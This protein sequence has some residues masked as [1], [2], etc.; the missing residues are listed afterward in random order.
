MTMLTLLLFA[1][2]TKDLP[3]PP[4]GDATDDTGTVDTTGGSDGAETSEPVETAGPHDSATAV[5]TS[6]PVETGGALEPLVGDC[7]APADL[8]VDPLVVTGIYGTPAAKDIEFELIAIDQ[9]VDPDYVYASGQG[10]LQIFRVDDGVTKMGS[11]SGPRN[12][13]FD[14]TTIDAQHVAVAHW[15]YGVEI[16]SVTNPGTPMLLTQL[17]VPSA[18]RTAVHGDELFVVSFEG[19]ISAFNI[20]NRASPSERWSAGLLGSPRALVVTD[21]YAYAADV[22]LGVVTLARAGEYDPMTVVH[23]A[24]D[25]AGALDVFIDGEHLYVAGGSDGLS[26]YSLADPAAP[27]R[28]AVLDL[29][30]SVLSV[31]VKNDVAWVAAYTDILAI[32]VSDPAAPSTI[33]VEPTTERAMAVLATD[34]GAHAA[35]W[36]ELISHELDISAVAP[37]FDPAV[38]TLYVEPDGSV[39]EARIYNRGT[40]ELV[41]SGAELD[42][43]SRY[44]VEA[45]TRIAPGESGILRLTYDGGEGEP[46][47]D[48][49]LATNDPDEP[50]VTWPIATTESASL[51]KALGQPAP[52]FELIDTDG[53]VHRLSDYLGKPVFITWFATW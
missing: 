9:A 45:E 48:L 43:P 13:W 3:A 16:V 17:D 31:S 10:G 30:R 7:E 37:E 12:Y 8:A 29:N 39:T 40:A 21:D 26:I 53:E 14:V 11:Y 33:A 4:S 35:A 41:L 5:D 52:D 32:D 24:P 27:E 46:I 25:S 18:A 42:D 51:Y 22:Q 15:E 34:D 50:V 36:M 38:D 49:C 44:T 2:T 47:S 20:V 23:T 1:C 28:V 19:D 6:P